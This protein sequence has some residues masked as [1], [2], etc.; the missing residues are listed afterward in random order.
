MNTL[1]H[2]NSN[3]SECKETYYHRL[4]LINKITT[5]YHRSYKD[6]QRNLLPQIIK[7]GSDIDQRMIV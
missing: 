1:I 5:Y 3:Y 2:Q 4:P 6:L 7:Q